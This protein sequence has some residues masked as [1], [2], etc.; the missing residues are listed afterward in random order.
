VHRGDIV[1]FEA[2]PGQETAEIHDL[3]KRVI[4]LPGETIEGR[5]GRIYIDGDL[6]E[7]PYLPDG[8]ASK[9][10]PA[11]DVPAGSLFVL[12]DNRLASKDST[13]FG[14]ISEDLIVGRVFF[15]VWPLTRLGFL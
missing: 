5:G 9:T 11:Y 15:R 10:F 1:V 8:A 2:P 6:L 13:I 3:V 7:E 4:G 12:G 14:P